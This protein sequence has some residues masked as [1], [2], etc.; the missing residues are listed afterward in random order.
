MRHT[1]KPSK[2]IPNPYQELKCCWIPIHPKKNTWKYRWLAARALAT[3]VRV[4][5][6][7]WTHGHHVTK[8]IGESTKLENH[9]H[10]NSNH[11][12]FT[13]LKA[14]RFKKGITGLRFRFQFVGHQH[15]ASCNSF[16][17]FNFCRNFNSFQVGVFYGESIAN[18]PTIGEI[19]LL[20]NMFL[21]IK[22]LEKQKHICQKKSKVISL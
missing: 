11:P 7:K 9:M 22:M 3:S 5:N 14:V 1:Q 18:N 16:G 10:S 6:T 4:T 2:T 12:M 21:Q 19:L 8:G 13:C 20:E 15:T 17:V